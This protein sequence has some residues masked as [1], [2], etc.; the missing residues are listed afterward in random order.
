M[1]L[2]TFLLYSQILVS[3]QSSKPHKNTLKFRYRNLLSIFPPRRNWFT[4]IARLT[5]Y[6]VSNSCCKLQ[7]IVFLPLNRRRAIKRFLNAWLIS[8]QI[9]LSFYMFFKSL[10]RFLWKLWGNF[11]SFS[12]PPNRTLQN[13]QTIF[14]FNGISFNFPSSL[15]I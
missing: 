5:F 15:H 4:R 13:H 8:F 9:F 14:N 2:Q 3:K 12:S 1:K 6:K 7:N 11:L 10:P